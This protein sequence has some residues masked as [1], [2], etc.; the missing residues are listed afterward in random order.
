MTKALLD[1]TCERIRQTTDEGWSYE[2]DD[3]YT[4]EQLLDAAMC[5][6]EGGADLRWPWAEFHWKPTTKRRNLVKAAALIIAEIERIDR[7]D[8]KD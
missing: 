8:T 3:Q 4:D 5:Y 2:H 7:R 6:I 1:V